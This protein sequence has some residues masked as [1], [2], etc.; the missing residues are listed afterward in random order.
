MIK[1]S[2]IFFEKSG[3]TFNLKYIFLFFPHGQI[4]ATCQIAGYV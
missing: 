3:D 4:K 2:I 1:V